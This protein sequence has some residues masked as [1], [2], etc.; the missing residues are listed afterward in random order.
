MRLGFKC[1]WDCRLG[2]LV[3]LADLG[4]GLNVLLGLL[5]LSLQVVLGEIAVLAHS[6]GIVRLVWVSASISHLG[7]T[8]SVVAVLAHVLGIV[9]SLSVWAVENGSSGSLVVERDLDHVVVFLLAYRDF[10]FLWTNGSILER[11]LRVFLILWWDILVFVQSGFCILSGVWE[12]WNSLLH[13]LFHG[14]NISFWDL[15]SKSSLVQVLVRLQ[16][17]GGLLIIR[18]KVDLFRFLKVLNTL[19]LK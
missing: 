1:L 2:D 16:V 10:I 9:L 5:L 12:V 14:K 19:D 17:V 4:L 3:G 11:V 6:R 13:R 15:L 8:S 18:M 7:L